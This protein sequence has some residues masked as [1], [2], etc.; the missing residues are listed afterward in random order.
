MEVEYNFS[1][2]TTKK[3]K[4]ICNALHIDATGNKK[5]LVERL[6]QQCVTNY[7]NVDQCITD[8]ELL[9]LFD[10]INMDVEK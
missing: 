5:V 3:L 1:T 6:N 2:F 4:D 7:K 9:D 8:M 10:N